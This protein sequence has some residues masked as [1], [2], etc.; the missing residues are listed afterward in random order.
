MNTPSDR[1]GPVPHRVRPE[2]NVRCV[3][4]VRYYLVTA[5]LRCTARHL[6]TA[7]GTPFETIRY[8]LRRAGT[9]WHA[10]KHQ[11]RCTRLDRMILCGASQ[12]DLCRALGF[13]MVALQQ[14]F[15]R[16]YGKSYTEWRKQRGDV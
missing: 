15:R 12:R 3:H 10:L 16:E 2:L 1:S 8:R 9:S 7:L 6:E 5:D 14:M 13:S 4:D 11:E